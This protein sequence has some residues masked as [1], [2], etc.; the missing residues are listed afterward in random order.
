MLVA[1]FPNVSPSDGGGCP[2]YVALAR[3]WYLARANSSYVPPALTHS[4]DAA[5]TSSSNTTTASTLMASL[6]PGNAASPSAKGTAQATV[7]TP[8]DQRSDPRRVS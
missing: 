4:A 8:I 6:P 5:L 3:Q 2:M 1:R 7:L